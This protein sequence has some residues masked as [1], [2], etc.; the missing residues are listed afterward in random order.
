MLRRLFG[1][2]PKNT[3]EAKKTIT[4]AP[5][6]DVNY[7]SLV[8]IAWAKAVEGNE[9]LQLW[10]KDNGYP[11]LYMATFAILLKDE[12]RNWLIENGYAHL[13]AMINGAEGNLKAQEWLLKNNFETLY[14]ITCIGAQS[15]QSVHDPN[16]LCIAH[17]AGQIALGVPAQVV[18]YGRHSLRKVHVALDGGFSGHAV[19]V[20][21]RANQIGPL[22][23]NGGVSGCCNPIGGTARLK[24]ALVI[25]TQVQGHG[26][27]AE[28]QNLA[29]FLLQFGLAAALLIQQMV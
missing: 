12:A 19:G 1:S 27:N 13:M 24:I 20:A 10:L 29:R 26:S 22:H 6:H 18:D 4:A 28:C 11:E 15:R 3:E 9:D 23:G 17:H 14:H 7:P 16:S 2:A 8:F 25:D 21:D 5:L